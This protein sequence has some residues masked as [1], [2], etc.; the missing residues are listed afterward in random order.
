MKKTKKFNVTYYHTYKITEDEV[1]EWYELE[2]EGEKWD[3]LDD[4]QKIF[5]VEDYTNEEWF[6]PMNFTPFVEEDNMDLINEYQQYRKVIRKFVNEDLKLPSYSVR[7]NIWGENEEMIHYIVTYQNHR[8]VGIKET[9]LKVIKEN[10]NNLS[11]I[12]KYIDDLKIK[13]KVGVMIY[14]NNSFNLYLNY[15]RIGNLTIEDYKDK[16]DVMIL[17]EKGGK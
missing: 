15:V 10:L 16:I 11:I 5:V 12:E 17:N 13:E 7:I 4:K 9:I 3:D 1:I 14:D 2:N 8:F 6:N